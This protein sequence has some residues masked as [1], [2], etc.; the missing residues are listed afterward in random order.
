MIYAAAL[1]ALWMIAP[2]LGLWP[3]VT[4]NGERTVNTLFHIGMK[5]AE[6][7]ALKGEDMRAVF[8]QELVEWWF[9]WA[10]VF[11][12]AGSVFWLVRDFAFAE[13][14][15]LS[16]LG[17]GAGIVATVLLHKQVEW[18]GHA[19][20]VLVANRPEYIAEEAA[21]MKL[22]YGGMFKGDDVEAGLRKR[23]WIARIL[24][25]ILTIPIRRFAP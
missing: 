8:A 10:V 4:R 12:I 20:E 23:F 11:S 16:F 17:W 7:Y 6:F 21:R 19:A 5:P 1:A 15:V 9:K 25:A 18:I 14:A 2:L 13:R 22:G 24:I 3:P